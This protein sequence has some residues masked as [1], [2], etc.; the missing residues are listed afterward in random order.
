MILY[1]LSHFP[2][3]EW[4]HFEVRT[5]PYTYFI[6]YESPCIKYHTLSRPSALSRDAAT[7]PA[8]CCLLLVVPLL[9]SN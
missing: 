5:R 8:A 2:P 7:L 4:F 6:Y 3:L 9:T 1:K